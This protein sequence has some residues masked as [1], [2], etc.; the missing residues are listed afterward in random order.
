MELEVKFEETGSEFEVKFNHGNNEG[1]G[2][3][4][5]D[6]NISE[7]STWSS[8][9]IDEECQQTAEFADSLAPVLVL[10]Y[11]GENEEEVT[12]DYTYN[13]LK[14]M[15][16]MDDKSVL[17]HLMYHDGNQ[18]SEAITQTVHWTEDGAIVFDYGQL[19]RVCLDS[20]NYAWFSPFEEM[21]IDY[22][23]RAFLGGAW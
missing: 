1:G 12:I 15:I 21:M 7:F 13:D 19:G 5:D 16:H 17:A 20:S 4:I 22:I 11:R 10:I 8:K 23:D 14:E 18:Y 6:K 9:K 2:V 3:A